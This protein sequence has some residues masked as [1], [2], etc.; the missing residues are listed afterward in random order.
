M[1]FY[2]YKIECTEC[3]KNFTEFRTEVKN[4]RRKRCPSCKSVG[5]PVRTD[6]EAGKQ[7]GDCVNFKPYSD[8]LTRSQWWGTCSLGN[9]SPEESD[10]SL[11]GEEYGLVYFEEVCPSFAK[12]QE[13]DS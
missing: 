3:G 1:I 13:S 9:V 8:K 2:S 12:A 7:C 10:M 6:G 5:S 4:G 11:D